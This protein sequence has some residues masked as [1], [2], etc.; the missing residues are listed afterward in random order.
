MSVR[1]L[2]TSGDRA[3]VVARLRERVAALECR[4]TR[5]AGQTV[6]STSG[7]SSVLP[8]EAGHAYGVDSAFLGLALAAGASRAGEWVGFTGFPDF[9]AEA[10]AGL[11][12]ALDRT[13]LVP[14]PGEHWLEVTAAL[15]DV[16]R[17]VVLRPT[18]RVDAKQ[19]GVLESRLRRR[20]A[21]LVVHGGWPRLTA[22]VSL[23]R[24][25]WE[26]PLDG[27][28]HLERRRGTLVVDRR[29]RPATRVGVVT[30]GSEVEVLT[31]APAAA[32]PWRRASG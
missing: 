28:G 4:T 30:T 19:A 16:L 21:V 20:S 11:G 29:G 15:V 32:T 1:P 7:L 6:P 24:S 10:A 13:V 22:S 25:L 23:E 12:V 5:S 9:G 26:G 31:P 17:V 3:E 2:P 27:R 8:L 18:V 14:E